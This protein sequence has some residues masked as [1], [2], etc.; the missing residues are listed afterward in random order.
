MN[1]VAY[2]GVDVQVARGCPYAVLDGRLKPHGSGWLASPGEVSHVVASLLKSF[3]RVAVGI[4]AP[5]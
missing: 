3:D 2:L 5:R 4:D 1:R